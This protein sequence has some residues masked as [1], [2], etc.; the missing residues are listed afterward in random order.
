MVECNGEGGDIYKV[1]VLVDQLGS[2]MNNEGFF[3]R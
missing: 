1:W 3:V 2:D